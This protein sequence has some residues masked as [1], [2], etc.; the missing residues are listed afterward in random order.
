V[1][2]GF[3]AAQ[4]PQTEPQHNRRSNDAEARGGEGR[5]AEERHRNRVLERGR[6]RQRRHGEGGG[7]QSDRRRHQPVRNVRGAKKGLSHGCEHEE[8][9]K[10]ADTAIGDDGPGQH[11]AEHGAAGSETRRHGT[12]DGRNRAAVFHELAEQSAKQKQRKELRQE[13]CRA[14]HEGLGPMSEQRLPRGGG[15]EQ[16]RDGGQ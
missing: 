12:G 4:R 10:Q 9:H 11:D 14:G 2:G 1:S 13:A 15:R 5:G 7:T 3:G 6:S 8:R 16:G